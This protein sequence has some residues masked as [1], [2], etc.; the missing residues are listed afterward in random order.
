MI[1]GWL[2]LRHR[3]RAVPSLRGYAICTAPRSGS[4]LLCQW[5]TST[6][7]LGRP[8]EYFNGPGRRALND[9]NYPDDRHAQIE[10][11]LTNG[12]TS[13]GI[14]GVKV[15]STHHAEVSPIVNWTK[16]LPRLVYIHLERGDR[17]GQAISWVR[18]QQ[19]QQYRS[20]QRIQGSISYDGSAIRA[21]LE[22]INRE[23]LH[24]S[25]FFR[26]RRREPLRIVYEDAIRSPQTTVNRVAACFDLD[27]RAIIDAADIDLLIQR[28]AV[29]EEWRTRYLAEFGASQMHQRPL[30]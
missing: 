17:L 27:G 1:F 25:E 20:T 15:F 24:W 14:Y 7:V 19:T 6:G 8:L 9:S 18:A 28:D 30:G 23:Y 4:N 21:R 29:T 22:A 26:R 10:W 16:A 3:H 5:L 2:G 13:N 11:I 12:A